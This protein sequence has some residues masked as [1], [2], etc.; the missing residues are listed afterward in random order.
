MCNLESEKSSN[1]SVTKYFLCLKQTVTGARRVFH[2]TGGAMSSPT[3][4]KNRNGKGPM[5]DAAIHAPCHSCVVE[6]ILG[7]SLV[8]VGIPA[9]VYSL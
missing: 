1:L 4:L 8:Q 2:C 3:P 7:E 6:M 5:L 9:R